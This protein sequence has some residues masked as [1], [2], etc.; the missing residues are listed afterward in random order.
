QLSQVINLKPLKLSGLW[1]PALFVSATGGILTLI[2]FAMLAYQVFY[3]DRV[4]PGVLVDGQ[5][6]GGQTP[7]QVVALLSRRLTPDL[8]R[9]ITVQAGDK[10][11]SFTG[12][13]LGMRVDYAAMADLAFAVG[14]QGNLLVD[15]LTQL[16]L[17]AA[18][19][20]IELV[21]RYDSGPLNR[22]LQQLADD[23][24]IPPQ[25]A[26]LIIHPD[27]TVEVSPARQGRRVHLEATRERLEAILA[28]PA[29]DPRITA[30]TQEIIPP[31]ADKAIETAQ[32]QAEHLLSQPLVFGFKTDTE[33]N[34]WRL[35]PQTLATMVNLV[36]TV[37]D[38]GQT[39]LVLKFK[40]EAFAPY[41][42]EFARNIGLE[43]VDARLEF[44][45][46]TGQLAVLQP[47]RDGHLLD[48]DAAYQ[49]LIA[50]EEAIKENSSPYVELPLVMTPPAVSS[51]DLDSLGIKEL[52]SESTSYFKG[53]SQ[54]RIHNIALAAARFHGVVIP[55]GEIFSFNKYLG[56]M[57]KENGFDESLIIYGD[58]TAVGIGGG[59]CQVSTTAFRTAFFGGFKLIERWAHGYRVSWYETE[60]GPGL[61]ATIYSPDI[62]FKFRNDTEHYLLIQTET[63]LAAGTLTFRFYGTR[64][65]R[66]VV[67]SEPEITNEVKPGPPIYEPDPTLP[68]G[69]TR[70]VDWAVDGMDVKVTRQ[71]K[72]GEKTLYED[73]IFS[74]YQPWQAVYKVGTGEQVDSTGRQ[75][76]QF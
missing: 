36:E 68:K 71:V 57:T 42:D 43:P 15:S 2:I 76:P 11:W 73:V 48:V 26:R 55:P 66:E 70:Q 17:M 74:Q 53:S 18:P 8:S 23:Y 12:Q 4:Y 13:E 65:G 54:G 28:D 62:D 25:N 40:R 56:E 3:L 39:Q 38:E 52:V 60:A 33:A 72:Q 64:P 49:R 9:S 22:A 27:A 67:V 10:S 69:V 63:D 44:D 5:P 19:Y 20:N 6:V 58:R 24:D 50:L 45:P 41:F 75:P 61:D 29:A 47:G 51:R 30:V 1:L 21:I 31:I 14:R 32:R 7:A 34:E 16:R 59:V 46:D 37:N 35:D